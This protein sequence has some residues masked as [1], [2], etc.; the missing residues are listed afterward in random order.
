MTV[1]SGMNFALGTMRVFRRL[2]VGVPA[3]VLSL[4]GAN[5]VHAQRAAA[6]EHWRVSFNDGSY[7]YVDGKRLATGTQTVDLML[8]PLRGDSVRAV[9]GTANPEI[10]DTLS[11]IRTPQGYRLVGK[12]RLA[13]ARNAVSGAQ[14]GVNVRVDLSLDVVDRQAN[15]E[16]IRLL[17]GLGNASIPPSRITVTAERVR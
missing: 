17:S 1:H 7:R 12:P 5:D 10:S 4:C 11:G 13:A 16:M 6:A 3:L 9:L 8:E 14:A 15:G 2:L